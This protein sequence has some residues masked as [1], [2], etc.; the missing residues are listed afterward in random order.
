LVLNSLED[1]GIVPEELERLRKM[2]ESSDENAL[3]SNEKMPK[4]AD[5][6]VISRSESR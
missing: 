2:L 1:R 3:Q 4:A 5:R 6:K